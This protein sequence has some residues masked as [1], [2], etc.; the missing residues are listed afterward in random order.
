MYLKCTTG[1]P[2]SGPA[3]SDNKIRFKKIGQV[4]LSSLMRLDKSN[5]CFVNFGQPSKYPY[6]F[7][8]WFDRLDICGSESS[9]IG[10]Y[11]FVYK[12]QVTY[13]KMNLINQF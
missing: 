1:I 8:K 6:K 4:N 10:F 9:R 12:Y 3:D 2:P 5:R 13:L 11:N 7:Q